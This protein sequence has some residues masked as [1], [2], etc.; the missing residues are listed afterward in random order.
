MTP[1]FVFLTD[2]KITVCVRL[3]LIPVNIRLMIRRDQITVIAQDHLTD[4]DPL[5]GEN[6]NTVPEPVVQVV[7]IVKAVIRKGFKDRPLSKPEIGADALV[8]TV[9]LQIPA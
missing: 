5:I 8:K 3:I 6:C 7:S 4:F 9:T 2:Q 1:E